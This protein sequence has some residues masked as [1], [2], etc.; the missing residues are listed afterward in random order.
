MEGPKIFP[1]Q[2]LRATKSSQFLS[3]VG[4]LYQIFGG[5]PS[6]VDAPLINVSDTLLRFGIG[7]PQ[8]LKLSHIQHKPQHK[9][10]GKIKKKNKIRE[11]VGEASE[12]ERS[13]IIVV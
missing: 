7:V 11:E 9:K 8:N 10:L 2:I 13:S 1:T 5:H 12:S 3:D 4:E 6:L